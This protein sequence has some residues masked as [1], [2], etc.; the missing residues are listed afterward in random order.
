[1][2][3]SSFSVPLYWRRRYKLFLS[4]TEEQATG[5]T[6]HSPS[7]NATA[8]RT[9]Q[10]R[11]GQ[12][13]GE[14]GEAAEVKTVQLQSYIEHVLANHVITFDLQTQAHFRYIISWQPCHQ[15]TKMI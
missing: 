2:F 9:G 11:L 7:S 6:K 3:V 5:E 13:A 1:M 8:G 10:R 15:S 14:S 4:F 12:S